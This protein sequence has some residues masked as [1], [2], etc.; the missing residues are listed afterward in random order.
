LVSPFARVQ[1][2][3]RVRNGRLPVEIDGCRCY[4][5]RNR[6][7]LLHCYRVTSPG[8]SCVL[9]WAPY[10]AKYITKLF[11]L[12][13]NH[14]PSPNGIQPSIDVQYNFLFRDGFVSFIHFDVISCFH[15]LIYI[16]RHAISTVYVANKVYMNCSSP[17]T[18]CA[19]A[20]GSTENI[21][22]LYNSM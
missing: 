20:S 3:T 4:P 2:L 16:Y 21:S 14:S 17:Y 5:G 12:L 6:P 8:P 11:I 22:R 10:Y 18:V 9:A 19:G 1:L 7:S 15:R 13:P